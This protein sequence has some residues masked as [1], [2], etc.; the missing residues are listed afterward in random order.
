M[1][2]QGE[3]PREGVG[4][5]A[6]RRG[7]P[8]QLSPETREALVLEAAGGLLSEQQ[9][10]DVTM[11]AIA[12]R[13]HMSKRTL[14]RMFGS[15]EALLEAAIRRVAQ[16]VF[17]PLDPAARRLA[18]ADRLDLL[19]TIDKDPATEPHRLELLRAIIAGTR[20]FPVLARRTLAEGRELLE[21]NVASELRTA[22]ARGEI[23]L[24]ADRIDLAALIL[25]D[26]AFDNPLSRLLGPDLPAPTAERIR[27]R[28]RA[29]IAIFLA[30]LPALGATTGSVHARAQTHGGI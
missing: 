3:C 26:M 16:T 8:L 4:V 27:T 7:R 13:A 10:D 19:L 29:A 25:I 17:Q 15:R 5:T 1:S 28:R 6:R 23:G 2:G 22:V 12:D 24:P 18:L 14:Y 21:R 20:T 11:T 9:L 30:G